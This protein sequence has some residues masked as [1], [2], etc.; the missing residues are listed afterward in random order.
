MKKMPVEEWE[1]LV[2]LL[3]MELDERL[4]YPNI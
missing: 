1:Y 2:D 4:P 3:M